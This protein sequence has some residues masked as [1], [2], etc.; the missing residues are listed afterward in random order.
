MSLDL[1]FVTREIGTAAELSALLPAFRVHTI[2]ITDVPEGDIHLVAR[3][4]AGDT[5]FS[6]RWPTLAILTDFYFQPIGTRLNREG[7]E[8][9]HRLG[10]TGFCSENHGTKGVMRVFFAFTND[11]RGF[12]EDE[13]DVPGCVSRT[14]GRNGTDL[15]RIWIPNGY[16]ST[17][18]DLID[19]QPR[20]NRRERAYRMVGSLLGAETAQE[21]FEAHIT[22]E[23]PSGRS[24]EHFRETCS[25]IGVKAIHI[26]L[27]SGEFPSHFITGSIHTGSL[28]NVVREVDA[29]ARQLESNG[30]KP[31]RRK[32]E[33]MVQNRAVPVTD[34]EAA[35]QPDSNYFEFHTKVTLQA[36]L[37]ITGLEA[38]CRSYGA[39]LARS[40]SNRLA[41]D[42]TQRFVTLR[43]YGE[44]KARAESRF[45][46]MIAEL[47]TAAYEP[48]HVLKE[49]VV[50]DTNPKLDAG[51]ADSAVPN[52]C[53]TGCER[54]A[55]GDCDF[56]DRAATSI[57]PI[58][59]E[60]R[61]ALG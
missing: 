2:P 38:I 60:S 35:R 49:Y 61:R 3:T 9:L 18:A 21:I 11:G 43:F 55:S 32:I 24:I 23:L 50:M 57:M 31:T 22:L 56:L 44:G 53:F 59:G 20:L 8:D 39:H 14:P 19:Y 52:T 10:P 7:L 33:A 4:I 5:W 41:G 36:G 17:L 58:F 54:L 12:V 46:S 29:L 45:S 13:R 16:Q 37:D 42:A 40:A 30:F 25:A 26:E 47:Q 28:E 34:D 51:W 6:T 27:P 15:D 1:A 48:S